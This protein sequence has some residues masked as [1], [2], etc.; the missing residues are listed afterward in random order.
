MN[1]P[2]GGLRSQP[3]AAD[4]SSMDTHRRGAGRT[5]DR[6]RRPVLRALAALFAAALALSHL[7][8]APSATAQASAPV[9]DRSTITAPE[10]YFRT[11]WHDPMDFSNP[12]DFD[13]TPRHMIQQGAASLTDGRLHLLGVQQAY[14]LRSDPGSYP[15]TAIRD[16]RT[17]P[18]DADKY[19]RM[20]IRMHSDRES[21][22]AIYF[23]RSNSCADGLKYFH[24]KAGWH[25]YDL[26]MG[27]AGDLDG[28]PNSSLPPVRGTPW[29]GNIEL[30]W[31]I[32]SFEAGNLP[33]LT[34][35]DVGIATAT[36]W[37]TLSIPATGGPADL[38]ID[39]DGNPSNDANLSSSATRRVAGESASFVAEVNGPRSIA[40]PG[41]VV[42]LGQTGRFYTVR[43]G[44]RSPVSSPVSMPVT[45]RPSPRTLSP[46]EGSGHDWAATIRRDAW[47]MN[48]PSDAWVVNAASAFQNG[49][50]HGW[51]AGRW[52]DPVVSL[53]VNTPIDGALFHKVAITITYEGPWGLEDAPGGGLVGRLVWHPNNGARYQVSDDLVLRT[54]TATYYVEMKTWPPSLIL[55]PAD[56]PQPIGW[57]TGGATWIRGLDF[58][59]HE[60]PGYRSWQID[61]VQVLRNEFVVP[62]QRAYD[63]VFIDDAW[64]PGTTADIIADPNLDPNDSAQVVL[65][66]GIPVQAGLN[67]FRWDG[68]PTAPGAYHLKVVV[69]RGGVS[70][71]SYSFG[72]LDVSPTGS[73]VK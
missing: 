10:E 25:S 46:A 32:T 39:F 30:L 63:V 68:R 34:V 71:H 9:V 53:A 73:P 33:A 72:Q 55:D 36:T 20:T 60:D 50:L 23:R 44:V 15:T 43:N 26:D 47:D 12:Q 29:G 3:A 69:H 67:R 5:T 8:T 54:G 4:D 38:W 66:R 18:L 24:I 19:R 14:L 65:A 52:N 41:N 35:D 48:Q 56:N 70:T 16:P 57:G 49:R 21:N 6:T 61:Q 13:T 7:V 2:V 28:L 42:R 11:A 59:P 58:H 51:S 40:V 22:A 64:A 27:G 37:P 31:M 17:R 62:G 1:D 45:S